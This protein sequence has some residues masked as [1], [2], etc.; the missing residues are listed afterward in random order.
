MPSFMQ[1]ADRIVGGEAAPSMIP[2]QVFILTGNGF[3]CGGTIID[4]CTVLSA[5]HCGI[6]TDGSIRAGSLNR[7]SGGQVCQK[8]SRY[9]INLLILVFYHL[10]SRY[11]TNHIKYR[12]S[13]YPD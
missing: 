7:Q 3:M 6:T 10:G 4:A 11:L 9:R 1:N 8:I 5:A 13:I 2:W 12:S